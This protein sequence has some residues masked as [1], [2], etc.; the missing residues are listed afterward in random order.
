M[1][2]IALKK[3]SEQQNLLF[4]YSV[5]GLIKKKN[6]LFALI[7]ILYISKIPKL[8]QAFVAIY[9]IFFLRFL[10]IIFTSDQNRIYFCTKCVP[11]SECHI[12]F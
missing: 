8:P 10:E 6:D 1:I 3:Q 4:L 7:D 5:F 11:N 2:I 9:L 12:P